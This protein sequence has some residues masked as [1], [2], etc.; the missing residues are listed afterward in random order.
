[1][2]EL[3]IRPETPDDIDIINEIQTAGF[4]RHDE[5]RLVQVIRDAGDITFS[6]VAEN[7]GEVVGHVLLS[8]VTITKDGDEYKELGL[9]PLAVWKE[10][11]GQ[12]IGAALMEDAL[13][14]CR[15]TDYG[16]VFVLGSPDFYPRFG[17]KKA[18]PLGFDSVYTQGEGD[19]PYFMVAI[20]KP[21]AEKRGGVVRYHQAFEGV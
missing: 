19:H 8:P 13:E 6:L 18:I 21:G 4:G 10:K 20:L 3:I 14:R 15:A 2:P 17:F 12:G 9:G 7:D 16:L 11:Q 1:M 5:A